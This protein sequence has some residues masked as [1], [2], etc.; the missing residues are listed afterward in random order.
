MGLVIN[1]GAEV[2]E[3]EA[4]EDFVDGLR[5]LVIV[6]SADADHQKNVEKRIAELFDKRFDFDKCREAPP[7]LDYIFGAFLAGTVGCLFSAG[8]GSKT[9][10]AMM[11]AVSMG[12]GRDLLNFGAL[13]APLKYG[14]V[15]YL[16]GEDPEI[17]THDKMDKLHRLYGLTDEEIVL[18]KKNVHIICL[19][20][21]ELDMMNDIDLDAVVKMASGCVLVV[22]DTLK[23]IHDLDE[24][25]NKDMS[26]L[27]H[28]LERICS[29]SGASLVFLHHVS[30]GAE[31]VDSQTAARGATVLIDNARWAACM[32][33]M[34][35][36]GLS[37]W[38]DGAF[39][40]E[41]GKFIDDVIESLAKSHADLGTRD[42]HHNYVAFAQVKTNYGPR[43][44]AVW[45]D[46]TFGGILQTIS[47]NKMPTSKDKKG[48]PVSIVN[49]EVGAGKMFADM[50]KAADDFHRNHKQILSLIDSYKGGAKGKK[51]ATEDERIA[52]AVDSAVKVA[53]ERVLVGERE[54]VMADAQAKA[55]A[56]AAAQVE[57][58]EKVLGKREKGLR[59]ELE[60]A[61]ALVAFDDDDWAKDL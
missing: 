1:K 52:A 15:L 38:S 29:K 20:G 9:T 28:R 47:L 17:I 39:S 34:T 30:K 35:E 7:K 58:V 61:R 41:T 49:L 14:K 31:S 23:R 36:D 25:L 40:E 46:K 56:A 45:F 3:A 43:G 32:I 2:A 13:G 53:V 8:G 4:A 48:L 16:S 19:Y 26:K 21:S 12:I 27:M 37:R 59:K 44:S 33:P 50:K 24:N 60:E 42:P 10:T 51:V 6:S 18:A 22:I 11:L 54:S 55:G 5:N 57:Q